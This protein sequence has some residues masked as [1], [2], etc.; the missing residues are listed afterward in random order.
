MEILK[1]LI[2]A[3]M[4]H[5]EILKLDSRCFESH[6][7]VL[8]QPVLVAPT[9]K[10]QS[11]GSKSLYTYSE[12][13]TV[14]LE[15]SSLCNAR[16]PMCLRNV[17]G[18]KT[19]PLLPLTDLRMEE[20]KKIFPK[21]FLLQL[22]RIYL[23]GNYGD[24]MM[25]KDTIPALEY[26]RQENKELKLEIFSNGSGRGVDWWARLAELGVEAHFGVD[27]I[28]PINA[29][30]RQNT[31]Y[32]LIMQNAAAFI[33]NG[34][35]AHWDF[36]VFRHNEH[37]VD[38]ARALS[39]KMG[40]KSFRAKRTGRFFSN[41]RGAVKERQEVLNEAGEI[42]YFLESP[43][44]KG[45]QNPSLLKES[46]LIEKHGSFEKY[47]DSTAIECKVSKEKSIFVTAEGLVFPCCWTAIQLYP[48]Y[49]EPQSTQMWKFLNSTS[50]GKESISAI[51]NSIESIV[52]GDFFTRTIPGAW[53]KTSIKEGKPKV[54]ARICGQEFDPFRDQF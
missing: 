24:P 13:K 48:W 12:I 20:I 40:F 18:G 2:V 53:S 4:S 14:H 49:S 35:M 17:S 22:K 28:G 8:L 38:E 46:A 54:C 23:C 7:N 36:I 16:C 39:E 27:G 29:I 6:K 1:D 42:Q 21:D 30:Y 51:K 25:A 45:L 37:Q 10:S 3:R 50:G 9:A 19:N 52:G 11:I 26:F 32:D 44:N 41:Q 43:S 47:L 5:W 33:S 31:N 34:G 15:I